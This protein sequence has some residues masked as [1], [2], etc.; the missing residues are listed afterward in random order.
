LIAALCIII[1]AG[2]RLT[3]TAERM[4]ALPQEE[5]EKTEL[6]KNIVDPIAA[7]KDIKPPQLIKKVNP[8]YPDSV[9]KKGIAGVVILE[10]TTD[11]Y[12]RV[13]RIKVLRSIPELDEAAIVAVKQWIYEPFI[14]EGKPRSVIFTVTC[15]FGL[16]LPPVRA[17]GD[18]KPPLLIKMVDPIYPDT[19]KAKEIEGTVI[20]ELTTDIYGRVA[21]VKV[22]R[23]IPELDE[24]AL[25]A[26]KQWIYEPFIMDK[27]PRGVIF[28]VTVRF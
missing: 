19:A 12:G 21:K 28:T 2:Y 23:S 14:M 27:K 11:I 15:R 5:K 4:D 1:L 6:E 17:T 20:L 16:D 26:V 24:A 25:D 18:I 10:L 8:I 13:A 22:L 9:K 3:F 7:T